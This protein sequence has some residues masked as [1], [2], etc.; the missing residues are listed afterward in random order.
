V[1]NAKRE[2]IHAHISDCMDQA[3]AKENISPADAIS[4]LRSLTR[5]L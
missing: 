5:Y 2:L 1:G 3:L 4:Q